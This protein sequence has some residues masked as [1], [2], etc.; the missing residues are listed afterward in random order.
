MRLESVGSSDG[1]V[2]GTE[3]DADVVVQVD[4]LGSNG[5]DHLGGD[6][7]DH[8]GVV[9]HLVVAALV[10]HVGGLDDVHPPAVVLDALVVLDD[11]L[12]LDLVEGLLVAAFL[13]VVLENLDAVFLNLLGFLGVEADVELP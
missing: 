8:L 11:E 4:V 6:L 7:L 10:V 1:A 12:L 9:G 13:H 5:F 2:L 3:G